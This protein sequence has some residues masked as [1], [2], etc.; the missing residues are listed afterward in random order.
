MVAVY[1]LYGVAVLMAL[2]PVALVL[3]GSPRA[4][5]VVYGVS[6]VTTLA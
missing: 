1:M 6:L 2:G 4:V 3:N 5:N